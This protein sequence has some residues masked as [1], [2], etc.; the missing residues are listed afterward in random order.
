MMTPQ[1]YGCQQSPY[2]RDWLISACENM[3]LLYAALIS[4]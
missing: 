3:R 4:G 2:H 1:Q